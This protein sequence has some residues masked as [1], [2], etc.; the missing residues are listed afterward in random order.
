LL[1]MNDRLDR[2]HKHP[3]S[4]WA[5]NRAHSTPD[6]QSGHRSSAIPLRTSHSHCEWNTDDESFLASV[7]I[8]CCCGDPRAL[9]CGKV[10]EFCQ[11][12]LRQC[13]AQFLT[14]DSI[15][16][17][18]RLRLPFAPWQVSRHSAPPSPLVG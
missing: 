5:D 6:D 1:T 4:T 18:A 14:G 13:A 3:Q 11:P 7:D 15:R 10:L 9:Q 2:I 12:G 17:P 16:V 8:R